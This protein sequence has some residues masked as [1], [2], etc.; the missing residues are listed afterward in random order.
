VG[1]A[2]E[3]GWTDALIE[4][5]RGTPSE[6]VDVSRLIGR[7]QICTSNKSWHVNRR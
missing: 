5:V 4:V 6:F 2:A 1:D 3:P 7:L